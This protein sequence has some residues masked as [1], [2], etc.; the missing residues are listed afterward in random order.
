[1]FKNNWDII[2]LFVACLAIQVLIAFDAESSGKSLYI[3]KCV[4]CHNLN[5]SKAGAIGPDIANASL[6]LV[7][8]KTQKRKYPVGYKPK[9]KTNVMPII[10]LTQKQISSIHNYL[11]E[12]LKNEKK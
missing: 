9:R 2:V 3:S 12:F 6:E 11:S 4:A 5:P 10:K 1:M 7:T 8:L